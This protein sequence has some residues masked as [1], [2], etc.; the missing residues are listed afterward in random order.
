MIVAGIT[1][2]MGTG[3]SAI[4]RMFQNLGAYIIDYDELARKVVE[5][6]NEAWQKLVDNFGKVILNVDKTVNR[7]KLADIVFSN[8]EK[9]RQLNSIIHPEVFSEDHRLTQER[10][11]IAPDGLIIKDIPLL[12]ELGPEI[13]RKLVDKIIVVYASPEVQLRRLISRG[14]E[15]NDALNRIKNQIPIEEKIKFADFVI[16][17]DGTPE[18]TQ[19]QVVQIYQQLMSESA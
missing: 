14:V 4:A 16:N 11:E 10:G 2:T 17:N 5:P 7:Q 9:L 3:K 15:K 18:E 6:G 1:G 19:R 8:P 12:I 13:S